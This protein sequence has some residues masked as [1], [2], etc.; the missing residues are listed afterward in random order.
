M[1]LAAVA[2]SKFDTG[3]GYT[4]ARI[5]HSVVDP[6]FIGDEVARRFEIKGPIA[7]FLLYRGM[8]DVYMIQGA[9]ERYALR[10]WRKTYREVD[11]VAYELD[12]LDFLRERNFDASVPLR[13]RDGELY[14]K[15]DTPEGVRAVALY[16]W[17]P[18]RKFGD[19]LSVETAENIGEAF[20]RF[21]PLGLEYQ[22]DKLG[23]APF[24]PE[25]ATRFQVTVPA[26]LDFVYDRPDD[27]RDYA[28]IAERLAEKLTAIQAEDVP[29][30]ICHCD[31]HP[32]N[33]HVE[34]ETGRLTLLDFDGLGEDYMMQDVQN[35]VWGN[36]F[37]GFSPDIGTGF[38]RGYERVRKFTEAEKHY[39]EL[40]LL[41][42]A[43]RLVSGMAQS[44]SAVGRGTLRFRGLDW[45]GDYIKT[46][47][48]PLGLL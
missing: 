17:A 32:S 47:A 16:T 31:F 39:T 42:K 30:G 6:D 1:T 41:A 46:R 23:N 35:F 44:S 29:M 36:L 20:A 3:S 18:G 22:R 9:E 19:C 13:T 2:S 48:R 45:L 33:V 4:L 27:L 11:E 7:S 24:R 21:H 38:E 15:L 26:L 5:S 34:V 37:Y 10:V 43:F 25:N 40:F 14:F 8:N 28:I 12:F